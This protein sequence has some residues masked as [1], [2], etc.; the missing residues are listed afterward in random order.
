MILADIWTA[1][2]LIGLIGSIRNVRKRNANLRALRI[3]GTNGP[4]ELT[5]RSFRNSE[6]IRM[7]QSIIGFV[8]GVTAVIFYQ[9]NYFKQVNAAAAAGTISQPSIVY[10][11]RYAIQWGLFFWNVLLVINIWYFGVIGDRVERLRHK[12]GI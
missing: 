4:A 2:A 12:K 3:K 6:V 7:M 9:S 11:Y 5:A 10:F 1:L 8:I